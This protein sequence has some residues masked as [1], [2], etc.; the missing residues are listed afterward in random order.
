VAKIR[1]TVRAGFDN[2]HTRRP[3]VSMAASEVAIRSRSLMNF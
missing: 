2:P 3:L 1:M